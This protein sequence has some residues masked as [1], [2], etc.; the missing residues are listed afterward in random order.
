MRAITNTVV[1]NTVV[2]NIASGT[3]G[4]ME[5]RL[6]GVVERIYV[7]NNIVW[8]NTATTNGADVS[9]GGTG[10]RREF[11]HNDAHNFYGLWDIFENDI[12]LA[13]SFR[14]SSAADFRLRDDSPCVDAGSSAARRLPSIDIEGAPRVLDG[15]N[16]GTAAPDIGCYE[17]VS[18]TADTDGDGSRD[19]DEIVAGTDPTDSAS[20][21]WHHCVWFARHRTIHS[22]ELRAWQG[23]QAYSGEQTSPLGTGLTCRV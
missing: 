4:G 7:F 8:G 9:I 16:D 14:N 15:N 13:P 6:D 1:N 21:F 20:F 11:S 12:D 17:F 23:V 22:V 3:G 2:G 18:S 19:E 10:S 5:F